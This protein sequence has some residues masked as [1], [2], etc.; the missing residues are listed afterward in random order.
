MS[1]K[2]ILQR[3]FLTQEQ[4]DQFIKNE[5]ASPSNVTIGDQSLVYTVTAGTER[6]RSISKFTISGRNLLTNGVLDSRTFRD[7]TV[8]SNGLMDTVDANGTI[9]EYDLDGS[10]LFL[11]GTQD[12][13][14]QRLG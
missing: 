13:G 6:F 12:T 3:M 5:A 8:S 11:F 10:L 7:I 9:Y 1:L 4:L 2:M 14:D